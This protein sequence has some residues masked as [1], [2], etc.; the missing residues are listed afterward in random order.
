M[1]SNKS[2]IIHIHS[3]KQMI[4]LF[5]KNELCPFEIIEGDIVI[6][7]APKIILREV[8][9]GKE[10]YGY[11]ADEDNYDMNIQCILADGTSFTCRRPE[12]DMKMGIWEYFNDD[13]YN[14]LQYNPIRIR[15]VTSGSCQMTYNR[16]KLRNRSNNIISF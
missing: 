2:V 6:T 7:V 1:K 10:I 4:E 8:I 3:K 13:K 9:S 12:Y 16:F 11:V 15:I 14:I 5:S